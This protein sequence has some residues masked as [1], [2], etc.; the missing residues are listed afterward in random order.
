M[1]KTRDKWEKSGPQ[2][3]TASNQLVKANKDGYS[4][5]LSGE[6]EEQDVPTFGGAVMCQTA[7]R[8][9]FRLGMRERTYWQQ[10]QQQQKKMRDGQGQG[11]G[12]VN[13]KDNQNNRG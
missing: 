13:G 9:G 3:N 4:A 5:A 8:A 12:E 1:A 7:W 10:H 6:V 11:E 2:I